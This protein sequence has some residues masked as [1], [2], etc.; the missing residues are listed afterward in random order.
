MNWDNLLEATSME[1]AQIQYEYEEGGRFN[2]PSVG[3]LKEQFFKAAMKEM[4]RYIRASD[5]GSVEMIEEENIEN[6]FIR[7]NKPFEVASVIVEFDQTPEDFQLENVDVRDFSWYPRPGRSKE[8]T[9]AS[10]QFR[11]GN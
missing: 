7:R 3:H 5:H 11:E 9:T 8:Y 4:E 6:V 10:F 2:N 1:D